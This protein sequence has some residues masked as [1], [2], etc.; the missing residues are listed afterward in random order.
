MTAQ[1]LPVVRE[2]DP[3]AAGTLTR[4]G[5]VNS[6]GGREHTVIAALALGGILPRGYEV[7]HI[8]EI[9][10]DN[11]PENLVVC[12]T[13][14]LHHLLHTAPELL[15]RCEWL[16]PTGSSVRRFRAFDPPGTNFC[17]RCKKSKP[18]GEFQRSRKYASGVRGECTLCRRK[19]GVL[20]LREFRKAHPV[21]P[22]IYVGLSGERNPSAKLAPKEVLE[23]R[24]L[25]SAG[26]TQVALAAQFG[27]TQS[28]IYLIVHR[29]H[30]GHL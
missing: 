11:R 10:S 29:K 21:A 28:A 24:R 15:E 12:E 18:L 2:Y 13:R 7:H 17:V 23:I 22:R 14:R 30:W 27:V 3:V 25:Y 19:H 4:S 16:G 1:A 6:N 8:N 9:K 5:Y 20:A 26:E